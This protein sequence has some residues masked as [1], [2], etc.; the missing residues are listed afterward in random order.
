MF[1]TKYLF[2]SSR[3]CI[4][5]NRQNDKL[6]GCRCLFCHSLPKIF[7]FVTYLHFFF[8]LKEIRK[9]RRMPR[10]REKKVK[11]CHLHPEQKSISFSFFNGFFYARFFLF[12]IFSSF[13]WHSLHLLTLSHTRQAVTSFTFHHTKAFVTPAPVKRVL[14]FNLLL[15]LSPVTKS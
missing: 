13:F 5:F 12:L 4:P 6:K 8:N 11:D 14:A 1:F 15:A 3:R 2:I 7:E 10:K 9:L